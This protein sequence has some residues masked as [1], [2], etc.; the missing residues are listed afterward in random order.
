MLKIYCFRDNLE[1]NKYAYFGIN[2]YFAQDISTTIIYEVIKVKKERKL[3]VSA[4]VSRLIEKNNPIVEFI[5]MAVQSGTGKT[6]AYNDAREAG[7]AVRKQTQLALYDYLEYEDEEGTEEIERA[8]EDEPA[9]D[10]YQKVQ[11]HFADQLGQFFG[12]MTYEPSDLSECDAP[13]R[14]KEKD[15]VFEIGRLQ[16]GKFEYYGHY[17]GGHWKSYKMFNDFDDSGL[18]DILGEL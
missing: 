18:E 6:Q 10:I 17:S 12:G 1:G 9:Y 3:E 7:I 11:E 8:I 5:R 4:A 13:R 16:T 15:F 2:L 14:M